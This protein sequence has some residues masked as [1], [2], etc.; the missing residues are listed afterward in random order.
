MRQRVREPMERNR[1][2]WEL[3]DF[4]DREAKSLREL[5]L[6][7]MSDGIARTY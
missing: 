4:I 1:C 2:V 7:L 3:A 5:T 6:Y